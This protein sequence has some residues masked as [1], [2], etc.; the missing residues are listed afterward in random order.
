M[1]RQLSTSWTLAL[2]IFL[3]TL[4]LA[5]FG[6][7]LVAVSFSDKGHIGDLP[8]SYLRLGLMVFIAVFAFI[9][10]KTIL[11]LRRI[12]A[13]KEYVYVT[14]YFK[15]RRYLH[16]DVEKIEL[17]TGFLFKYA[18]LILKGTGAFGNRI[19][20]LASRKRLELFLEENP[21]LKDWVVELS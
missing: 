20:F 2:R 18:T 1:T 14:D 8:V 15:N 6:T 4:W 21:L 5:F 13:D 10:W 17:S 9:F 12:D 11:K 3:P 16:S 7:F 19:V